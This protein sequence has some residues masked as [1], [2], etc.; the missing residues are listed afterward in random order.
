MS[1]KKK[2]NISI[3]ASQK[4]YAKWKEWDKRPHIVWFNL[5]EMSIKDKFMKTESGLVFAW[6]RRW[7]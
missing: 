1:D 6:G 3:D 2:Q 5:Y 7:E 4:Q